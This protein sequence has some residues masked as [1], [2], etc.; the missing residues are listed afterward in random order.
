VRQNVT[1]YDPSAG[2]GTLLMN[3]AHAI[4]E[5]RCTIYSQDISQKSSSL[6]RLNLILNNLVHSIPN[7]I[8]GNT[9]LHPYHRD[10]R[11]AAEVRL[12]RLQSAL[13]TGFLRLPRRAGHPGQPRALLRRHPQIPNKDKDKMAI[14]L[15]FIQHII[16]SLA[17]DGKAAIVVPTGFITAQSGIEKGIREHLVENKMLAGVVSMPSNIFATTGTNVSILFLDAANKE[18][19][20]LIDASNLG[21]KVKDGKNQKTLLSAEEENRI[22]QTFNTKQAVEDFSVVVTY[23]EIAEK[24]YSFS[25]GQYFDVVKNRLPKYVLEEGDI[26]FGR[27]GAI[28]RN[29]IINKKQAGWF[30]G[31]DGIRLRFNICHSSLFFSYMLRKPSIKKWLLSNGQGAIMPTLNQKI[32]DRLPVVFPVLE[33]QERIANILSALDRKIELNKL[34]NHELEKLAKLLY[35]YWFVQFD[36]PISAEQATALGKPE[37]AGKP[38]KSSGGPMVYS[39][40]LKRRIPEC[41]M[42]GNLLDVADFT[43]GIACQKYRPTGNQKLPVI[44]I[45]EMRDGFTDATEFVGADSI[46]GKIIV[47]NGDIL[48][49]WSASLEVMVWTGGKGALNQH[50]FKVTSTKYPRSIYYFALLNYLQHFKMLADLRKTT[51][52]HITQDHLEQSRVVLPPKAIAAEFDRLTSPLFSKI[53]NT[54]KE[55]Q[56][57]TQLRDWLLPMLMNGQV[58]ILIKQDV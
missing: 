50:I 9:I 13:Q 12:H 24:N 27:K 10:E 57:L 43:N 31:S 26:V 3:L 34:I 4:G 32:L 58:K 35:D 28:D 39:P 37:L 20:V 21:T 8:Q 15:L 49:S 51:M 16:H 30:L 19:V 1:C 40:V 14:Y 18:H 55:N 42:V 46:P 45:K 2:S 25:A 54:K 7:I 56:E 33:E 53:L 48:F 44:K 47:E 41:W 36:F 22:I 6:L 17:K 52:G 23:E 11:G 29:A 38:Y 5:E